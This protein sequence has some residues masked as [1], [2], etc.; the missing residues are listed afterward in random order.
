MNHSLSE[1]LQIK[2]SLP[3]E[4]TNNWV[5]QGFIEALDSSNIVSI[6]NQHGVIEY[7]NDKFCE[8]SKYE[9]DELLGSSHNIVRHEEM[10]REVFRDLWKTIKSGKVWQGI[11]KNRAKDG[12]S[13]VVDTTIVPIIDSNGNQNHYVSIRHDITRVVANEKIIQKQLVDE[14]TGLWNRVKLLEDLNRTS[15]PA[16]SII[17]LDGFSEINDFYGLGMGDEMLRLIANTLK[18]YYREPTHVLYR[19]RGDEFAVLTVNNQ[20][21]MEHLKKLDEF[22]STLRQQPFEC[23]GHKIYISATSGSA[24]ESDTI[25]GKANIALKHARSKRKLHQLYDASLKLEI[26]TGENLEWAAKI[27]DAIANGRVVSYYQPIFNIK[28]KKIEKYEALVRLIDQNGMTI[29]PWQFL[30][31]AK[32]T[33]QYPEITKIM[34]NNAVK[35]AR[36]SNIEISVNLSVEDLENEDIMIEIERLLGSDNIGNRIVFELTETEEVKNYNAV[37]DFIST[38]KRKYGSKVAIDDFGSGYSNFEHLLELEFDYLKIDGSIVQKLED[39]K[40]SAILVE[41]IKAFTDKLGIKTIAEFVSTEEIF[42]II[43]EKN[44]DYAQGYFVGKPEL[45]LITTS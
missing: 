20:N 40:Q 1:A 30:E 3:F 35:T 6:A 13:Y 17:N 15:F 44:I 22:L 2:A 25:L 7:A 37:S 12:S 27:Q 24:F 14:L 18:E 41:A 36:E 11:I 9:R 28:T 34:L 26:K 19:L 16:I 5:I 31:I 33:K 42:D 38:V 23:D 45:N 10:P 4:S 43:S 29:A 21:V 32:K 8:I 39:S